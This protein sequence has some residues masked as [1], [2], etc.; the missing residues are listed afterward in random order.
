MD[1]IDITDS[2]KN[3]D[4]LVLI[5]GAGYPE[6]IGKVYGIKK[7][8]WGFSIRVKI[9]SDGQVFFNSVCHVYEF[10]KGSRRPVGAYLLPTPTA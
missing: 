10:P 2:I 7:S 8:K 4:K 3:G 1:R 9:E 5:S 6:E